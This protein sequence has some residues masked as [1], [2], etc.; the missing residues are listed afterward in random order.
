ALH[1]TGHAVEARIYA[2]D[3]DNGFLPQTGPIDL[4]VTPVQNATVRIDTGVRSGD[5]VSRF[6][7]PMIAKLI[8]HAK[9]RELANSRMLGALQQTHIDGTTT[10]LGFLQ[11]VVATPRFS[12][13]E[14][15]TRF[16]ELEQAALAPA[17]PQHAA[18]LAAL[19]LWFELDAQT[20]SAD[21]WRM[22][23]PNRVP[24]DI[25]IGDNRTHAVVTLDPHDRQPRSV[26]L[27]GVRHQVFAS[28]H[29]DEL[30]ATVDAANY[31]I[32]TFIRNDRG[33]LIYR[34][35]RINFARVAADTGDASQQAGSGDATAPMTGTIVKVSASNGRTVA[36]GDPIIIMEAMKMEHTLKAPFAGVVEQLNVKDGD[37]VDGGALLF[38]I[39]PDTDDA[40]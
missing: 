3:T 32:K 16:I 27:D 7:D 36:A 4:F 30:S 10:N 2:E 33:T 23:L 31:R 9:T 11:R 13:G 34:H 15:T 14:V 17:T 28:K 21:G 12:D 39:T 19:A 8:T 35:T 18:V 26:D 25:A 40:S 37:R 1:V 5:A 22:N 20:G 6:Y 29:A 38:T 24:F